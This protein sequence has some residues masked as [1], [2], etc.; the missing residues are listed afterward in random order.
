MDSWN[1]HINQ[2]N[3]SLEIISILQTAIQLI[4]N[5]NTIKHTEESEQNAHVHM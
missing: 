5:K 2:I 1:K 3:I 4:P